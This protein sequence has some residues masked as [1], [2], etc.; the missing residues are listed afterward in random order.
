MGQPRARAA[1]VAIH[2]LGTLGGA[3][4][5]GKAVNRRG[6]VVGTDNHTDIAVTLN[7]L[8]AVRQATGDLA[9]AEALYR[10]A[11]I[12]K[13]RRLGPRHPDVAVTLNNL[14][15]LHRMQGREVEAA[16]AC[17]RALVIFDE[18]LGADHPIVRACRE[19]LE[20]LRTSAP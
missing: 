20:R 2:D 15:M 17:R 11:L 1:L 8:A 4:S 3:V 14:A 19:N 13:E 5:Q 16:A 10:R 18:A 9:E 6:Q 7:N 12:S